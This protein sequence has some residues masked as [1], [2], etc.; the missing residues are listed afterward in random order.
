MP[1]LNNSTFPVRHAVAFMACLCAISCQHWHTM[2]FADKLGN[3]IDRNDSLLCVGLDPDLDKMPRYLFERDDIRFPIFEFNRRII[4]A[5]ADQVCAFKPQAAFY[6]A[7]GEEGDIQLKTT[8][9]YIRETQPDVA[10]ILDVKRGDI[11]NTARAYATEAFERYGVDAMTASP[12]MG[13]DTLEPLL[14]NPNHGVFVLCRTSNEGSGD[15]QMLDLASGGKLYEEVARRATSWN[16]NDNVGLVMGATYPEEL[17]TIREIVGDDIPFLVPGIGAQGG[18]VE[19][20]LTNGQNGKGRGLVIN[21]SRS[22]IYAGD[23]E[24]FNA[25]ARRAAMNLRSQINCWRKYPAA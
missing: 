9:Q 8:I 7:L 15:F 22:I 2:T 21:A 6:A 5:T 25:E 1:I 24:D 23:G 4:D 13:G 16:G 3:A 12:Y 19:D 10:I 18:S 14:A 17:R 20:V 11:G